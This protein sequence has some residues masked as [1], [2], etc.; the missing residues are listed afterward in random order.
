MEKTTT[1]TKEIEE[2]VNRRH[3]SGF[4]FGKKTTPLCAAQRAVQS[5]VVGVTE[6]E[7]EGNVFERLKNSGH[8]VLQSKVQTVYHREEKKQNDF[9]RLKKWSKKELRKEYLS[10]QG[11]EY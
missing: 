11:V 10:P 5:T 7:S 6:G 4:D 8:C 9:G 3:R 1:D 2:L